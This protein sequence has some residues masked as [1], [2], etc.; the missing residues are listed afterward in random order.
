MWSH[1]MGTRPARKETGEKL[2]F[3]FIISLDC[4]WQTKSIIIVYFSFWIF[5][6]P[7]FLFFSF[8]NEVG[9]PH[10]IIPNGRQHVLINNPIFWK[11]FVPNNCYS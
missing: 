2:S 4:C 7:S 5:L 6:A 10:L 1:S 9:F 8:M 3:F 11:W